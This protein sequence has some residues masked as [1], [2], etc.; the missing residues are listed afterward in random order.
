MFV[1]VPSSQGLFQLPPGSPMH[2]VS[3]FPGTL[4]QSDNNPPPI[5]SF[6]Y[7]PPGTGSAERGPPPPGR[8]LSESWTSE[9]T[10]PPPVVSSPQLP[11]PRTVPPAIPGLYCLVLRWP[12]LP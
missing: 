9:M 11:E 1:N 6:S 8:A 5:R 2:H 7:Q 12:F 4:N 10:P 3:T